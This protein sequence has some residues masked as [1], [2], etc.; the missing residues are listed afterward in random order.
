M[1]MSSMEPIRSFLSLKTALP[2][3]WRF[4]LQPRVTL[5]ISVAATPTRVDPATWACETSGVA[6]RATAA[7]RNGMLE[8]FIGFS[9]SQSAV[10]LSSAGASE[11]VQG[12]DRPHADRPAV[13]VV[14]GG[15]VLG[16]GRR[17]VRAEPRVGIVGY[18]I[19]QAVNRELLGDV[20]EGAEGP[21][22][23][24]L[25][26]AGVVPDFSVERT[27]TH[28]RSDV[29]VGR[30]LVDVV[31]GVGSRVR[32]RYERARGSQRIA[33]VVQ[34]SRRGAGGR[35]LVVRADVDEVDLALAVVPV[36]VE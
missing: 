9:Y 6:N 13:D 11:P 15:E 20:P 24:V 16:Q 33:A 28:R 30:D 29:V 12:A 36:A 8:R 22:V 35:A 10:S 21:A 34:G 4:A 25:A 26:A 7:R 17:A 32:A 3:T 18:R 23:R 5:R 27:D 2:S 1:T 31:V 14:G 19:P